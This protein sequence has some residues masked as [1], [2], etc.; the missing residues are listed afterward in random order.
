MFDFLGFENVL[1]WKMKNAGNIRAVVVLRLVVFLGCEKSYP[2]LSGMMD[3]SYL[4]G[5]RFFTNQ[6]NGMG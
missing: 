4:L 5:M 2:C 3:I 6:C 1:S